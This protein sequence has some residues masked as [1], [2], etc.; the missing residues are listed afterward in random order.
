M[1]VSQKAFNE[2]QRKRLFMYYSKKES[3]IEKVNKNQKT[4]HL[5]GFKAWYN[6]IRCPQCNK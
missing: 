5:C 1:G 4:C 3:G 2:K 6:F